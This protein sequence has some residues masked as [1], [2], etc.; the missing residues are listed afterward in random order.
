[1]STPS[2]RSSRSSAPCRRAAC[3]V[4]IAALSLTVE[5]EAGE[6]MRTE[7][8]AKFRREGITAELADAGRRV[9]EWWTDP[10]GDYALSL[11]VPA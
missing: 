5:F 9:A 2:W 3:S 4:R 1:M 11:A 10:D 8:S 6:Q 7:I